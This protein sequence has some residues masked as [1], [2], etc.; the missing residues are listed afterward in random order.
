[1][2]TDTAYKNFAFISYS[3]R[4]M[5]I[6]RWL[7]KK[8]EQFRLPAKIHN[9]IEVG[10]KYIRPI[11]RDESDLST[12]YLSD[13]L[14]ENLKRSK[15]LI[16]ICS[17]HSADS[18]W[19]NKETESFV[20]MG[21]LGQIIPVIVSDKE[22]PGTELFPKFLRD[23]FAAEPEKELLGVAIAGGREKSLIRIVARML[24]VSFDSLWQRHV[25]QRRIKMLARAVGVAF[26]ALA[27]YLFALPVYVTPRISLEK[28]D[29]PL[30]EEVEIDVDGA[31][32]FAGVRCAEA[33]PI[34]LPGYKRFTNPCVT[35]STKY[36]KT[37]TVSPHIGLGLKSTFD[38]TL[39]RDS[40]F[41]IFAGNVYDDEMNPLNGVAVKVADKAG[42]TDANGRFCINL[43]VELQ[44]EYQ[45]I[46]LEK[47]G[48]KPLQRTGESPGSDLKYILHKQ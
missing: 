6:A 2:S 13:M 40:T 39:S 8:L 47:D 21:H 18:E 36:F 11:F 34:R 10:G 43:P 48:F 28:A 9:D 12:G 42:N 37:E 27:L 14:A 5:G 4:D 38:V 7:Q 15:F 31:K 25:R 16:L 45:A 29:L 1:M 17:E 22:N 26:V 3:H 32:Y 24:D 33:E 44:K 19:V 23:L 30:G 46:T 41:A 35:V 20:K